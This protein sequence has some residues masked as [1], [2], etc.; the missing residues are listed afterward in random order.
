MEFPN[1]PDSFRG[2]KTFGRLNTYH[3]C[4][5]ESLVF[6]QCSQFYLPSWVLFPCLHSLLMWYTC[7]LLLCVFLA[8]FSLYR[9]ISAILLRLLCLVCAMGLFFG[10][11]CVAAC[12]LVPPT[13]FV[14]DLL[15]P[16]RLKI[17]LSGL[18][19][20]ASL[21]ILHLGPHSPALNFCQHNILEGRSLQVLVDH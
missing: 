5:F 18:C 11:R 6:P 3:L 20:S 8:R 12:C 21:P 14:Y 13:I 17:L 2:L 7:V 16:L 4:Y 1:P 10:F 15:L 9:C 19:S